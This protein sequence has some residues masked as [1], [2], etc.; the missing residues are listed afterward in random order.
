MLLVILTQ[1]LLLLLQSTQ[2]QMGSYRDEMPVLPNA[3]PGAPDDKAVQADDH[4]C[5][6][7]RLHGYGGM[8]WDRE[9]T[10]R[11]EVE[12]ELLLNAAAQAPS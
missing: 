11:Q 10:K 3:G 7:C 12:K 5:C 6:S 9:W 8:A 1:V 2:Q 4:L